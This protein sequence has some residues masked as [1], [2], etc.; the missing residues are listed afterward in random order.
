[1]MRADLALIGF[2]HVGRRFARLLAESDERLRSVYDLDCRIVA[3]TTARHGSVWRSDGLDAVAAAARIERGGTVGRADGLSDAAT[4]LETIARLGRSDADLRV[5]VETTTLDIIAGQPA[6]THV[7]A[8]IAAEC[9]VVTANKGPAAFEYAALR[10]GAASAGVSFLFE[11]A[12]M[13]GVPIFNL[14]RETLPLVRIL[15]FRG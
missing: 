12:V 4:S 3:V 5:V 10:D 1:M 9:H 2:G 13:D 6:I 7:R 14:V 8:A 11:G 15:G